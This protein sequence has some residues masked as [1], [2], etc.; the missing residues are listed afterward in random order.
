MKSRGEEPGCSGPQ[1]FQDP[2]AAP[3][4]GRGVLACA[5]LTGQQGEGQ[6]D[7]EATSEAA[8]GPSHRVSAFNKL[9]SPFAACLAATAVSQHSALSP[10][11]K[12][13]PSE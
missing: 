11:R 13:I 3:A 5:M 6:G 1:R 9:F 7:G 8:K 2:G 4:Q 12:A 10:D